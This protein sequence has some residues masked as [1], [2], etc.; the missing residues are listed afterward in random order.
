MARF[1]YAPWKTVAINNK[2]IGPCCHVEFDCYNIDFKNYNKHEELKEIK[3]QFLSGTEPEICG[4]CWDSE[5]AGGWSRRMI[6]NQEYNYI[7]EDPV[8]DYELLELGIDDIETV[9]GNVCNLQCRTCN[10]DNSSRWSKVDAKLAEKGFT[11]DRDASSVFRYLLKEDDYVEY[12]LS[13]KDLK[14][15]TLLG[16]E[17]FFGQR[18]EHLF[19]LKNID[20]KEIEYITNGTYIPDEEFIKLWDKFESIVINFSIDGI[21]DVF[22]YTR[23]PAKW[24]KLNETVDYF[25]RLAEEKQNIKLTIVATVSILNI[26]NMPELLQWANERDIGITFAPVT[27][28]EHFSLKNIPEYVKPIIYDALEGIAEFDPYI[29]YLQNNIGSNEYLN[30]TRRYINALDSIHNQSFSSLYPTLAK[31]LEI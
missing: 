28:P 19:L 25:M 11:L 30:D 18:E 9:V 16:G 3:K 1:C 6:T 8:I 27:R 20:V 5:A 31:K 2:K 17:P 29:N 22:E 13:Y 23:V 24:S 21:G 14:R 4:K 15:L 12:L 7:D 26:L 10:V